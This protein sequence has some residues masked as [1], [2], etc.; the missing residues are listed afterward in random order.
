M[1][2]W[3]KVKGGWSDL[4]D[5]VVD[6]VQL[7]GDI[8][9][10]D[11][12]G[13]ADN[14]ED[15]YHDA[16]ELQDEVQFITIAA[17]TIAAAAQY[18]ALV[19][20]LEAGTIAIP[21]AAEAMS[22]YRNL[23]DKVRPV[24]DRLQAESERVRGV[25]DNQLLRD[26]VST[27]KDIH[28]IG[29]IVSPAYRHKIADFYEE[30]GKL[31]RK[32]FGEANTMASGL[33]LIRLATMDATR[34]NGQSVDLAEQRYFG[35]ALRLSERVERQSNT[36]A[37]RPGLF[38]ADMDTMFLQPLAQEAAEGAQEQSGRM[39]AFAAVLQLTAD[40][41]VATAARFDTYRLEL[42]PFLSD[43]K[44]ADLDRI[45]RDFHLQVEVPLS[46]LAEFV[47]D[48]YPP[49]RRMAI[50]TAKAT[51]RNSLDVLTLEQ[52][53][54]LPGNLSPGQRASQANRVNW[55]LVSAFGQMDN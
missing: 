41:T 23:E 48:R 11:I 47:T 9:T 20:A 51:N 37:R 39:T 25:L 46:A 2:V 30:T 45:R 19:A 53:T 29:L 54:A 26:T 16:I 6:E 44:L 7:V 36:Y 42:D 35:E 22:L 50:D 5:L 24:T 3:D 17:F 4:K 31:S 52:R 33:Q 34:A 43:G 18:A 12:D 13:I 32:V 40:S 49:V 55:W 10:G 8:L 38:W 28:A 21:M 14:V 27:L 1:A 15:V